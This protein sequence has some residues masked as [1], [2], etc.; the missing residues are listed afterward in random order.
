[1]LTLLLVTLAAAPEPVTI[2][3][4]HTVGQKYALEYSNVLSKPK[5]SK[6][7]KA[8]A[9]VKSVEEK[10]VNLDATVDSL[11]WNG[12]DGKRSGS[13]V[14]LKVAVHEGAVS[15]TV[16]SPGTLGEDADF[17]LTAFEQ[18]LGDLCMPPKG[19]FYAKKPFADRS[20]W[21]LL[22]TPGPIAKLR[23]APSK[24]A[25]GDADVLTCDL[26][27]SADDGFSGERTG[28]AKV[29]VAQGKFVD[30]TQTL[31]VKKL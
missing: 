20:T 1:M 8:T 25:E 14:K 21:E 3:R 7:F 18:M 29:P 23:S 11:E 10:T 5:T 19:P 13:G 6:T 12:P 24:E 22:S 28:R 2:V 30:Q 16:V 9:V 31:K 17:E 15:A 26:T 4:K 27:I